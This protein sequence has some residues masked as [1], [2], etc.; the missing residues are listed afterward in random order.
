KTTSAGTRTTLWS[1]ETPLQEELPDG[2]ALRYVFH[3]VDQRPLAFAVDGKWHYV[4]TDHHGEATGLVRL[5]DE[6]VVWRSEPLGF[7]AES[8]GEPPRVPFPLRGAGQ[9]ADPETGLLY[10]R[11]RYYDGREGRFLSPDPV[12]VYGGWNLYRFCLNQPLRLTD[13]RGLTPD[14]D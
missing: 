6:R 11:A 12:G 2:T 7:Y 4:V 9:Q 1:R 14:C 8:N 13:P 10:Q 5:A 3:P